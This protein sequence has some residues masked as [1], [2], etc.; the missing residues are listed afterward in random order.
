MKEVYSESQRDN[1]L[2]PL[3]GYVPVAFVTELTED[4][5]RITDTPLLVTRRTYPLVQVAML[6]F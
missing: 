4:T 5:C 1:A 6:F 3:H 2:P